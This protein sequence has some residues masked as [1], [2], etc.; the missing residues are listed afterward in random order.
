MFG[1]WRNERC[2]G[3]STSDEL[4]ARGERTDTPA[5]EQATSVPRRLALRML[6]IT[7]TA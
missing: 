6:R 2:C 1:T 5:N 7:G 4:N 3:R